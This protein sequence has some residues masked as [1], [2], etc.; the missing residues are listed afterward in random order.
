MVLW[1]LFHTFFIM[2]F[3][4]F[5]GGYAMIPFIEAAVSEYGWMS[6][7]RLTNMIAVAGM[8]PGPIATNSAILV[9]YAAAGIS[10]AIIS[11]IATMLPP[12]I[13]VV[14]VAALLIKLHDHPIVK[15]IF[16]GLKPIVTSLII[17]AAIRFAQ[18]NHLL[19]RSIT[20]RSI[21]LAAIFGLSLFALVKLRM[22]PIFVIILSG[23][24]GVTL[25]S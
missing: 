1:E 20:F 25:Y 19:T 6:A 14:T 24:A 13:L 4:S 18:S 12:M 2:G 15:S 3:I 17:F 7:E 11:A 16:Y 8:S 22:H 10:G 21:S 9:G 5:G 23:I